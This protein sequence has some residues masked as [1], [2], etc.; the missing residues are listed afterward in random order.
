MSLLLHVTNALLLMKLAR[1][2]G[3]SV[4]AAWVASGLFALSRLHFPALLAATSI[5]ELLSLTFLLVA[6][7]VASPRADREP[8]TGTLPQPD[9]Q[10]LAMLAFSPYRS[11]SQ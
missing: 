4:P 2:W 8:D 9:A 5:G 11:R 1:R 3:A 7:A 6:L 10:W